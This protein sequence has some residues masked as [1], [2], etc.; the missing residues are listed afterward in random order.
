MIQDFIQGDLIL[1]WI[2]F[3]YYTISRKRFNVRSFTFIVLSSV[4]SINPKLYY[5]YFLVTGVEM[6]IFLYKIYIN[7]EKYIPLIIKLIK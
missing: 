4:V 7:V 3:M 5:L 1:K 6:I 2:F